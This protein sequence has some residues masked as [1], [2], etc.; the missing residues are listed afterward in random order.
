[1]NYYRYD[2]CVYRELARLVLIHT[3]GCSRDE[4]TDSDVDS[5]LVFV[6][7]FSARSAEDLLARLR[8]REAQALDNSKPKLIHIYMR[9]RGL[10]G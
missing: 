4:V 6:R 7:Q 8:R 9:R 10:E 1:M 2:P 3:Y 5:E